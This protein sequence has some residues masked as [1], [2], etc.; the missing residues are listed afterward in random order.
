M[1]VFIP[2]PLRSYAGGQSSVEISAGTLSEA[3]DGLT[4]AHPDLRK[5]LFNGDG[6]CAPL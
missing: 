3:L 2:T 1:K 5:H 4:Q 6:K